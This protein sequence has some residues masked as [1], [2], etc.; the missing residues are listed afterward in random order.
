MKFF[1]EKLLKNSE[2]IFIIFYIQNIK[3]FLDYF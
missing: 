1:L 2:I 3:I